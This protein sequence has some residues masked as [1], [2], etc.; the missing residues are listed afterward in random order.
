MY[1]AWGATCEREVRSVSE[2]IAA[3]GNVRPT[4]ITRACPPRCAGPHHRLKSLCDNAGMFV[5]HGFSRDIRPAKSKRLQPLA[6]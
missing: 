4:N 1:E 3:W 2:V 5:G 6:V